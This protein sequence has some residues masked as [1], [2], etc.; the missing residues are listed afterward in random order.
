MTKFINHKKTRVMFSMSHGVTQIP[1]GDIMSLQF[2]GN[3]P[4]LK[5]SV[6]TPEKKK[7]KKKKNHKKF[8]YYHDTVR[9]RKHYHQQYCT[10]KCTYSWKE[11]KNKSHDNK[12]FFLTGN[13]CFNSTSNRSVYSLMWFNMATEKVNH[14]KCN[15]SLTLMI[16]LGPDTMTVLVNIDDAMCPQP[17]LNECLIS[18]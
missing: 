13:V 14:A 2:R 7:K 18:N 15:K 11:R 4:F 1:T 17:I 5:I 3:L 8:R 9:H 16:L 12:L 6:I 10:C